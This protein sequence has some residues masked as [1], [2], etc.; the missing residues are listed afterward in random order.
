[1]YAIRGNLGYP[2]I[3]VYASGPIVRYPDPQCGGLIAPVVT[4]IQTQPVS[5]MS[6]LTIKPVV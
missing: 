5:L 1:M 3:G 2:G 6:N 4:A